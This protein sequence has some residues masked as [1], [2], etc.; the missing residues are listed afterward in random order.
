VYP[1]TKDKL[2]ELPKLSFVCSEEFYVKS[3]VVAHAS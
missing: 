3:V 1:F 2:K